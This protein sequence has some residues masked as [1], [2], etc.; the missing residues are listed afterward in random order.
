[1]KFTAID[2]GSEFS[3]LFL[4]N[5]NYKTVHSSKGF[6]PNEAAKVKYMLCE[7]SYGNM[8]TENRSFPDIEIGD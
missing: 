4:A 3:F 6:T 2:H 5:Y 8:Q 1:M 7:T